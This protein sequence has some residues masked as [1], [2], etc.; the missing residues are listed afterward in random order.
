MPVNVQ[1]KKS[2][3]A[4]KHGRNTEKCKQYR[5]AHTKERNKAKRILQSNGRKACEA[6]CKTNGIKLPARYHVLEERE[7]DRKG[8]K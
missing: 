1:R 2:G 5:A 8:E 6:Y 4:R 3:G 7:Y